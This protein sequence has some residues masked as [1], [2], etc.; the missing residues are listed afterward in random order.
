MRVIDLRFICHKTTSLLKPEIGG[1]A[2]D[3][4]FFKK[5]C[6][7]PQSELIVVRKPL[8]GIK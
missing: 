8:Q 7:R 2:C 4:E 3:R 5:S 6:P 1:P